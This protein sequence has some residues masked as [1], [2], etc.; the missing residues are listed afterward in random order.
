MSE[1]CRLGRFPVL[2]IVHKEGGLGR[3]PISDYLHR[4]FRWTW[5]VLW[6]ALGA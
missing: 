3:T 4:F 1:C 2:P 6:V 5:S